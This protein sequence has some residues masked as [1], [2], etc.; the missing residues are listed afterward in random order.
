MVAVGGGYSHIE[1]LGEV[2]ELIREDDQDRDVLHFLFIWFFLCFI[3]LRFRF[4]NTWL[5]L[6]MQ[7]HIPC[8]CVGRST[9]FRACGG[10]ICLNFAQGGF[11]QVTPSS[12]VPGGIRMRRA[13]KVC[14]C[15]CVCVCHTSPTLLNPF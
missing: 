7:A 11:D 10:N 8:L 12:A 9:L 1:A 2:A 6:F 5:P 15:V 4:L 3:T 14:V 13:K